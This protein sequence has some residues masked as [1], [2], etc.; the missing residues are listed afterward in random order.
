MR[1]RL[2]SIF[3]RW[4]PRLEKPATAVDAAFVACGVVTP[5]LHL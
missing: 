5:S 1:R 2:A 4:L 3:G